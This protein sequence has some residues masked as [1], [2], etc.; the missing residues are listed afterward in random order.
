MAHRLTDLQPIH[1]LHKVI[2]ANDYNRVRLALL[3]LG[4]PLRVP[5][6]GMRCLE[7]HLED[8]FWICVDAC[9]ADRP[10][11][12]WTEFEAAHRAAIHEPVSCELRIFHVH[13]GLVMG[14]IL[15]TTGRV[16]QDRLD[17]ARK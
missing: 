5:L 3:R 1:K 13:G 8:R 10:I 6:D 11:L 15:D 14:E 2:Q 7:M 16:L 12:A 17:A 9:M 4:S